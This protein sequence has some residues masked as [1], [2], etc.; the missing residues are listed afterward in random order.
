MRAIR[1]FAATSSLDPAKEIPP[2]DLFPNRK[3]RPRPYLYSGAEVA[4]LM[5]AAR[6]L[7]QPLR[8]ATFET[9]IRLLAATGLRISEAMRLDRDDLDFGHGLM[10]VRD[11]KFG[12]S[13]EV[14]LH[15]STVKAL[16]RH[17]DQ[18]D[19]LSPCPSA[20]NFFVSMRG[21]RLLVV[22]GLFPSRPTL[23][24]QV[25]ALVDRQMPE[26]KLDA[27][28]ESGFQAALERRYG[29]ALVELLATAGLNLRST[30]RQQDL[31]VTGGRIEA[32]VV[33]KIMLGTT[34]AVFPLLF[35]AGLLLGGIDCPRGFLPWPPFCLGR[36]LPAS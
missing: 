25:R 1:S 19:R 35:A 29:S 26:P 34:G 11:S 8:A 27:M 32:L 9:L 15:L 10:I 31:R 36:G 12:K 3:Y 18:R 16:R 17:A 14:L 22:R 30:S 23:A 21:T 24:T 20:P 28:Q 13:R 2:L 6:E 4:A 5:A 33:E 7:A